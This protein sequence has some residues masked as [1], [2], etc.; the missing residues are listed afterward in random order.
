MNN[1]LKINKIEKLDLINSLFWPLDWNIT[2]LKKINQ[3]LGIHDVLC[4][5][6]YSIAKFA[7]LLNSIISSNLEIEGKENI[8]KE[9]GAILAIN[10]QSWLDAGSVVM[11]CPRTLHFMAKEELF[12]M[13][14]LR[15]F[16]E[17]AN[18]ISVK[19]GH[20]HS[21]ENVYSILH[22]GHLIGIFPEGTIPGEENIPRSA[23]EPA[24]GLLKG[25]TG[26]VRLALRT[27]VPIIPT[28][29][30]GTGKSLPPEVFPRLEKL[31]NLKSY[32]LKVHFG[33]P[34]DY[35]EYYEKEIN[36][37]LLRRLTDEL[38]VQISKLVID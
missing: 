1:L 19:R 8:P 22:D 7:M 37:D 30:S 32:P 18:T 25:K 31:P 21:L 5:Y 6:F 33:K 20:K 24:T 15:H 23:V 34:I 3:K 13:P 9:G 35:S 28:G 2:L 29:V 17:L 14:I 12:K 4:K 26:A 11:A 38:M 36:Y 16:L 10:H 27:R